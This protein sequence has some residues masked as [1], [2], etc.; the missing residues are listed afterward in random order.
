MATLA[1]RMHNVRPALG[2]GGNL[3]LAINLQVQGSGGNPWKGGDL[4]IWSF[5]VTRLLRA[6]LRGRLWLLGYGVC[7]R[8]LGNAGGDQDA[9]ELGE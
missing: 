2:V 5:A 8:T 1:L 9:A 4:L 6:V 7:T 3:I